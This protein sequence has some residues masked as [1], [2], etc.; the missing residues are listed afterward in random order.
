ML[1]MDADGSL[2]E[3]SLEV[4]AFLVHP[5]LTVSNPLVFGSKLVT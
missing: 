1:K 2:G 4:G 3:F 5:S